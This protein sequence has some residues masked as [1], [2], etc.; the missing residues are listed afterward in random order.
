M[1]FGV[2]ESG[3]SPV[4]TDVHADGQREI[5]RAGRDQRKEGAAGWCSSAWKSSLAAGVQL[6][7]SEA[8]GDVPPRIPEVGWQATPVA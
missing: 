6:V 4:A 1:R 8:R 2:D 7:S 5:P 3:C